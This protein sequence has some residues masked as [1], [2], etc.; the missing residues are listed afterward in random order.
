[1]TAR[2]AKLRRVRLTETPTVGDLAVATITFALTL[3]LLAGAHGS[4]RSLDGI[5]VLLAAISCFP[6]L[7]HRRSPLGVFALTAAASATLN[8]LGYALGP[9]FGPTAALF[10]VAAD[11][12]TRLHV[13]RTA[14][15]VVGIFLAH[16]AATSSDQSGFPTSA[17]LFG[18]VVWGGAWM[19]GDQVRQRR[20]RRVEVEERL[21]RAERETARERRL[22][23]AEERT[24]IARDLHDSAAHAI[25]V[26]LVQ[27]GAARLLQQRDPEAARAALTTIEEVARETIG[28][29][30]RLVTGL[31][32]DTG[33]TPSVVEPP[34]GLA[35]LETLAERYR[36][37]GLEIDVRIQGHPRP[38][39]R[40]LDQA[41]Y[42]ILQESLTNAARHG[43][44]DAEV[45]VNYGAR[46]LELAIA[47]TVAAPAPDAMKAGGHGI[48]GMRE[49]T[50]LLGGT[51]DAGRAG[52]GFRVRARL[53]YAAEDEAP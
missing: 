36:A 7:A 23:A 4:S 9:P 38:L 32:D 16:V 14:A 44:G 30:D 40:G 1:V 34:T 51:L 21:R 46:E 49:R 5:S 26:I 24:R 15:L 28:E 53:P 25:N 29:I 45:S 20:R 13:W 3:A 52:D 43:D 27:A 22:A 19:I 6:L 17:V 35:A 2:T 39:P 18:I 12:R 42:R 37:A 33:E 10:F 11:E 48:L 50:S 31:R 8:G 47:N 41:A